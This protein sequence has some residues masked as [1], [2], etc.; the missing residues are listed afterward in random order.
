MPLPVREEEE[1]SREEMIMK[2]RRGA[3]GWAL[4]P[5]ALSL[6]IGRDGRMLSGYGFLEVDSGTSYEFF[7]PQKY[8]RVERRF[9]PR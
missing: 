4:V 9:S 3:P 2:A 6:H 8:L 5:G 7:T 1:D